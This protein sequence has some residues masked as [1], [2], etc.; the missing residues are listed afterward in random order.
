MEGKCDGLER[1]AYHE[2]YDKL[3]YKLM[4]K[5]QLYESQGDYTNDTRLRRVLTGASK[6]W[7]ASIAANEHA[8]K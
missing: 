6:A 7:R 5:I 4:H 2:Y 3:K 1:A 8:G